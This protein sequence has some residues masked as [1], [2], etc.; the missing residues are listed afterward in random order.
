MSLPLLR[1]TGTP[2][3]QGLQHGRELK[4][5]IAHNVDVYFERFEKQGKL[6]RQQVLVR[7][8]K[9]AQII[10]EQNPEYLAGVRGISDGSGFDLDQLL[11]LNVRYEILYH[12][13]S[14]NAMADGCTSFAILP[15]ASADGHLLMGQN[16]DWIPQVQGA[17]VHTT[18][19]NG[20]HTLS[21]TEAGIV[22]GK[23]GLNSAGLGLAVNGL[24]TTA[25]DWSRLAKP[26]HVRCY[27]ILRAHDLEAARQ[28]VMNARR[29][30]STNFLIG[31]VPD[32]VVDIEAA[33]DQARLLAPENGCLV[34]TNH[35]LDPEALGVVEP[36]RPPWSSTVHRL[37]RLNA[38]LG[39]KRP[40]TRE[41]IQAYLQDHQQHPNSVCRHEDSELPPAER[42]RTV[43]GVVMD[44]QAQS[45]FISDGPPCQS[46]Y[47]Q[48]EL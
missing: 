26:F 36:P 40:V 44:L 15:S 24:H 12:Q 8:M 47:Q 9:Y 39:A 29:A 20:L 22:G 32:Q 48:L 35:F 41:E 18:E 21:F 13:L 43:T 19:P 46:E 1:L 42:Y 14:S 27:E 45:L 33:P 17:V 4:S 30:C 23:I 28:V 37:L 7:A 5:R 3:E 38:L 6:P 25:D 16:W 34:H 2:Y 10:A 11:A 31:Q